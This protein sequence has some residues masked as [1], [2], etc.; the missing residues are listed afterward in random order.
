MQGR[1]EYEISN[2][3]YHMVKYLRWLYT[4]SKK[5]VRAGFYADYP[6]VGKLIGLQPDGS[7]TKNWV[8]PNPETPSFKEELA[9]RRQE[10]E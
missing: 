6:E 10:E 4:R 5:G 1:R 2:M 3:D 8:N 7:L 9:S